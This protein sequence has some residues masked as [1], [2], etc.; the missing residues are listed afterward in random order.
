MIRRVRIAPSIL[1]ADLTRLGEQ[2]H[3]AEVAG[4]DFI[5]VDVMDG[6]FVPNITFGPLVVRAVRRITNL[7]RLVHL[8][9][10]QPDRY[11][12]GFAEAG[13]SGLTV[14]YETCPH[15]HRSVQKVKELGLLVGVALN[16]STPSE[17]LTEIMSYLD[18]VLVMTVNPG[19]GG[20]KFITSMLPKIRRVR[21]MIN[22]LQ[23]ECMLA[24]DGGI[25]A[26]TAPEVVGA[27]ADL[28]VAGQ[29]VFGNGA[30]VGNGIGALRDSVR[31]A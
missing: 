2:V 30:G 4:A 26:T 13:A 6:H 23:P 17:L 24:V 10:E 22:D 5:H 1:D 11:M 14:H 18:V 29:A 27:G 12:E 3:E 16:P 15:L 31:E 7:P 25:N 8:M 28:L 19:F 9:T 21:R 20:Q